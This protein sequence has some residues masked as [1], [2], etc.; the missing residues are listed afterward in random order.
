MTTLQKY[1]PCPFCGKQQTLQVISGQELMGEDQEF[2]QHS[3]S[4]GVVCDASSPDGKGGCGAMGGFK[5]TEDEAIE[6]WNTRSALS[7]QEL[8]QKERTDF[9][10][11]YDA[12]MADAKRM[13][14]Q[15]EQQVCAGCGIPVGDVHMS[16][17]KSGK[18]PSRVSNGDTA[19][20]APQPAQDVPET[21]FGNMQV[22]A[23][24]ALLC[25]PNEQ[26]PE[27]EHWE[28]FMACRIVSVL[29]SAQ[30]VVNQQMTTVKESLT[31]Q[32]AQPVARPLTDAWIR[33]RTKQPW[34]FDTVKQWVREIEAAHGIGRKPCS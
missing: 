31:P 34:V 24:Y 12:G 4:F 13:A 26:P 18:W 22:Q 29:R 3:D 6:A 7:Q 9:M 19:A 27:G 28:G 23:V 21:N 11:G 32:S 14:Q 1:L 30:P 10:A 15:G 16:T 17:C 25:D 20:P 2:W 33:E 5:P 8:P